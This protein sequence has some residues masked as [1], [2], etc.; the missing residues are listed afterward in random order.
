MKGQK[1]KSQLKIHFKHFG[2]FRQRT[3]Y[4]F[5]FNAYKINNMVNNDDSERFTILVTYV[6]LEKN[7]FQKPYSCP[8]LCHDS[9][10]RFPNGPWEIR[11]R[12]TCTQ[13][14]LIYAIQCK[15]C[16]VFY[17]GATGK[18]LGDRFTQHLRDVKNNEDRPVARNFNLANHAGPED[19][20]VSVLR[21]CHTSK[22]V[23]KSLEAGLILRL[24]T[25]DGQGLN[26][27]LDLL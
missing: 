2:V 5:T 11:S 23:R 27:R 13:R 7:K 6:I 12:F 14:N 19:I 21:F 17:I 20:E 26:S 16:F 18:R 25:S 10:L 24:G 1:L 8:Y 3:M 4:S 22:I 15:R 9:T